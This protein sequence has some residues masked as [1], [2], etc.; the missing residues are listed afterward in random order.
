MEP[1]PPRSVGWIGTGR[2]G[3]AMV[4][5]LMNAGHEVVVY[6][7]TRSKCEPLR[8]LGALIVDS[9]ADL[10]GRDI[11]FSMVAT[12]EDFAEVT[13]GPA[14]LLRCDPSPKVLVDCSTISA[15]VSARV[16]AAAAGRG[17]LLL[18]A[19]VSGNAKV[20][21]AGRLSVVASGPRSAFDEVADLLKLISQNVTY[22][23]DGETARLVKLAHNVFLGVVAQ[24]LAEITVMA[25][26]GGIP[27]A[28][29]LEFVNGSVMGSTFTR[30]KTPAFVSVDMT[31]RF[32]TALL[33]KDLDAGLA[34]ARELEV[35]M[36]L[37]SLTHQMVQQAIGAGHRDDDFAALL[38][39]A[40][41]G[42]GM[43]LKPE[44]TT[45]SDGL[46]GPS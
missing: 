31:P 25:E 19:P 44:D 35:P 5:R 32:T 14:G 17:T 7:R 9:V 46:N 27:R 28:A 16:R 2:M 18:A 40:A 36:P 11:V 33:R 29:F 39:R 43:E 12:S 21:R 37:A 38:L 22:A 4:S 30:Y 42:A 13:I 26:K 20:V 1:T 45:V 3:Y 41:A 15:E 24:S 10:A 6:N 23:G 34:A 8:E